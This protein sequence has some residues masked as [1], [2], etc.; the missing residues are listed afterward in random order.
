MAVQVFRTGQE[1]F[2]IGALTVDQIVCFKGNDVAVSLGYERPH[3]AVMGHVVEED[4][5]T[6]DALIQGG[7]RHPSLLISNQMRST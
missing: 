2:E 1:L 3:K 7:V 6:Y 5:K 4:K